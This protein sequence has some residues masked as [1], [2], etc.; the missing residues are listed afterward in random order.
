MV[1]ISQQKFDPEQLEKAHRL[2][3]WSNVIVVACSAL[4][5]TAWF[6]AHFVFFY[7]IGSLA[8]ILTLIFVWGPV[9]IGISGPGEGRIVNGILFIVIGILVTHKFWAGLIL[10]G[11][12]F[13]LLNMVPLAVELYRMR[14][15]RKNKEGGKEVETPA[16]VA[17]EGQDERVNQMSEAFKRLSAVTVTLTDGAEELNGMAPDVDLLKDYISSGQWLKDFEADERGEIGPDVD[18]SVLS[19]DG[20]YNLMEDLDDLMHTFEE[21]QDK[22]AADPDLELKLQEE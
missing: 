5:I 15:D 6:T 17:E 1:D 19:E 21:L 14:R 16:P 22:F 2:M 9:F 4:G 7:I 10:G 13:G 11:C 12:F 18:R 20:L 3:E 8:L